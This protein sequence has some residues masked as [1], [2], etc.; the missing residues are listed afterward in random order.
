MN[1]LILILLVLLLLISLFQW[2]SYYCAT[3]GLLYY[4]AIK[5]DN[6]LNES[7]MKELTYMAMERTIKEFIKRI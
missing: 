2:F 6:M 7:K 3:R 5:Y 4:L 1:S